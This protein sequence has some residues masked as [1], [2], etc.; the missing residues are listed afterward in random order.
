MLISKTKIALRVSD[1]AGANEPM[2]HAGD[3]ASHTPIESN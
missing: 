3:A 1:P 2:G